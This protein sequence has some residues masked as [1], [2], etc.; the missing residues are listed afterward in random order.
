VLVTRDML[1]LMKPRALVM[2]LSI[3]MGG[4]VETSRPTA[5]PEPV[6]EV[7]GIRHFCVPNLPSMAARTSTQALTNALLPYLA[8]GTA[9]SPAE[10]LASSADLR[11]GTYVH[12]G[13]CA[14]RSLASS[15]G[16]PYQPVREE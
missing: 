16:L 11:R 12:D 8:G 14:R 2:D 15:F 4:S 5:F 3:D 1:R 10:L 9:A 7:D 6:Y 13:S